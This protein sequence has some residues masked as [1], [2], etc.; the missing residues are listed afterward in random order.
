VADG[1]KEGYK[2]KERSPCIEKIQAK[3]I[4]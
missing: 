4:T 3:K 2:M 1:W